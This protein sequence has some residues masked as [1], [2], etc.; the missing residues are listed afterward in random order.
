MVHVQRQV[1][2]DGTSLAYALPEGGRP[3]GPVV[4]LLN[5]VEAHNMESGEVRELRDRADDA[6]NRGGKLSDTDDARGW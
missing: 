4:P 6:Y 5:Y 1:V 3:R 2:H